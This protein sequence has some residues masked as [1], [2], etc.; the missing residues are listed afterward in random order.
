MKL[1]SSTTLT[2]VAVFATTTVHGAAPELGLPEWLPQC[3]EE[4]SSPLTM[5][6]C[7]YSNLDVE[8]YDEDTV[9]G[10]ILTCLQDQLAGVISSDEISSS[11]ARTTNLGNGTLR[12]TIKN[13]T[14]YCLSGYIEC[15]RENIQ[16][17]VSE[18]EPCVNQT[19]RALGACAVANRETCGIS[20]D[21]AWEDLKGTYDDINPVALTTCAGIQNQILDSSCEVMSCC[22]PCVD[23]YED[24]M[25]CVV[26]DVLAYTARPC[27]LTCEARR[28]RNNVRRTLDESESE[29]AEDAIVAC[30]ET[31]PGLTGNDSSE[32]ANRVPIF[33]E[34]IGDEMVTVL[35]SSSSAEDDDGTTSPPTSA[36]TP[37]SGAIGRSSSWVWNTMYMTG[38]IG[39]CL[40]M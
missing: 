17:F 35:E 2:F 6:Q 32:L 37:G 5:V 14:A 28:R 7:V 26:N 29:A 3:F 23:E 40:C 38:V 24:L 31:T 9:Q 1:A 36:P 15:I 19:V 4:S 30:M 18:L 10:E 8:C 39:A 13:A 11:A 16:E 34:C 27:D 33:L 21:G 20:C 22:E 25:N 12:D